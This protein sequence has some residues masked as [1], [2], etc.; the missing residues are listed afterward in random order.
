M[1][2]AIMSEP[3]STA[4]QQGVA[5]IQIDNPPVNALTAGVPEALL[6]AVRRADGHPEVRAIV[7][8]CAGRTDAL[9]AAT[10]CS[11][12]SEHISRFCRADLLF[13]VTTVSHRSILSSLYR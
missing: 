5:V 4:I 6:N 10:L 11:S 7:V 8:I 13:V 2:F 1:P 9:Y 12:G 3:V